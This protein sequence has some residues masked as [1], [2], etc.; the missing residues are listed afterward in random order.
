[1]QLNR[2][3]FR[4]HANGGLGRKQL[5]AAPA[6]N[7]AAKLCQF[8]GCNLDSHGWKALCVFRIQINHEEFLAKPFKDF[9]V[10]DHGFDLSL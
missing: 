2:P 5:L 6:S 7:R 10:A 4:T 1:M 8:A 3:S 9:R